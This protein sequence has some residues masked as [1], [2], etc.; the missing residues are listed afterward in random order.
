V[1]L[2]V[3][4]NSEEQ[5]SQVVLN[6]CYITHVAGPFEMKACG[7]MLN[8]RAIQVRLEIVDV[9]HP[10]QRKA[11]TVVKSALKIVIAALPN[12]NGCFTID[13]EASL[14]LLEST[15]TIPARMR[16]KAFRSLSVSAISARA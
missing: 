4:S 16:I 1:N 14:N 11:E 15:S 6:S 5:H 2:I 10:S 12:K 8:Q 7:G 3:S 9:G 13:S